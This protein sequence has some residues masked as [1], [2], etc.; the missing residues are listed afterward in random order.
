MLVRMAPAIGTATVETCCGVSS[1]IIRWASSPAGRMAVV[2]CPCLASA[3]ATLTPLPPASTSAWL[4]RCT[5]PP[6]QDGNLDG[7]VQARVGGHRDDRTGRWLEMPS[8]AYHLRSRIF[9]L[10]GHVGIHL[11]VGDDRVDLG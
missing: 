2:R 8:C 5:S 6:D 9:D 4:V 1:P 10:S 7:V 11:A 3:R